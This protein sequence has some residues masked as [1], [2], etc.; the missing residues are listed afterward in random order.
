LSRRSADPLPRKI[1]ARHQER[2]A[3]IYV[4]QSTPTQVRHRRTSRDNQYALVERARALG[5]SGQDSSGRKGFQELVS[6]VSLGHVGLILTYEASRLARNNADWYRLLDRAALVGALLAD[7]DGVCDPRDYSDRVL[8][9]LRGMLREAELHLLPLRWQA[10]CRRQILQ[11]IYQQVL[12]YPGLVWL[13]DGRAGCGSSS[14]RRGWQRTPSPGR[15]R[16]LGQWPVA[17]GSAHRC[18]RSKR[19]N[20]RP[21]C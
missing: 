19:T 13:A 16:S 21:P 7:A 17:A 5:Q 10:G 4:R 11:R 6:A 18:R 8:L 14:R 20:R 15:C 9:G 12:P 1:T 3:Y 2:C